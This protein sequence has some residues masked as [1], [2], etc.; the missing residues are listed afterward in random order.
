MQTQDIRRAVKHFPELWYCT[1]I[2]DTY[3]NAYLITFK[4]GPLRASAAPPPPTRSIDPAIVGSWQHRRKAS[5]GIF[6]TATVAFNLMPSMGGKQ[7]PLRPIFTV[8]NSQKALGTRPGEC[9]GC[10][11]TGLPFSA[12]NCCTTSDAW[13]GALSWRSNHCPCLPLVEPLPPNCIAQ[14]LHSLHQ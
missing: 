4:I 8:G 10:V 2:V 9:G 7:V 14:P 12:R 1:V 5:F 13:L 6:R 11:M 3:G